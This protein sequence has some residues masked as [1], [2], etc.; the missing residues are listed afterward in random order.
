M[1]SVSGS[2]L[3]KVV[4]ERPEMGVPFRIVV[5]AEDLQA[6][7]DAATRGL[8]RVRSLNAVFSDY[9]FDS[10][11]S[12]LSR[13]AGMGRWDPVSA[14]LWRVL[15]IAKGLGERSGGAFD[16]TLGSATALWRETRRR[17]V[18]PSERQL[19]LVRSRIGWEH[20]EMASDRRALRLTQPSMLLDFGG[21]AKGVALDAAFEAVKEAG[22]S[23]AMVQAGGDMVL[24]AAPP[25]QNGWR[26]R[27]LPEDQIPAADQRDMELS[28]VALATSGDLFQF[29]EIDGMRYSH[30][31]DPRTAIGL[32]AQRRAV[33]IAKNATKADPVATT[34]CVL[35]EKR[36]LSFALSEGVLAAH[37]S[38]NGKEGVMQRMTD[39]FKERLKRALSPPNADGISD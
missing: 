28:S 16:V 7:R 25:G 12:R 14:E 36:S 26:V 27:V 5:Y 13:R 35:G 34:M 4:V 20:L 6:A 29:V 39:G 8:D 2:E 23:R 22:F 30:I 18:F 31:L 24:G 10:E 19:G 17:G 15:G 38:S 37:Y 3:Q 1:H 33:V 11:V 32:T 9:E 21:I